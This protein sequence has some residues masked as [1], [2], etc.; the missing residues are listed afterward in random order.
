MRSLSARPRLTHPRSRAEDRDTGPQ[1][2]RSA[3]NRRRGLARSVDCRKQDRQGTA[4]PLAT[5]GASRRG[6]QLR[7]RRVAARAAVRGGT[8]EAG[9]SLR[10]RRHPRRCTR[11]ADRN[12]RSARSADLLTDD[13]LDAPGRITPAASSRFRRD[14]LPSRTATQMSFERLTGDFGD[15]RVPSRSFVTQPHIEIVRQLYRSPFHGMPAYI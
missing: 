5:P 15:G 7:Q 10:G 8:P 1:A 9:G 13:L 4:L 12:R 6:T 11:R 14:Q 2:P 3:S